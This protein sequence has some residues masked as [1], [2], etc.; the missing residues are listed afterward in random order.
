MVYLSQEFHL[1]QQVRGINQTVQYCGAADRA[2][3]NHPEM[4]VASFPP[5][6]MRW[7]LFKFLSYNSKLGAY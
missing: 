5:K 7:K 3:V 2:A 6:M 4:K 1:E